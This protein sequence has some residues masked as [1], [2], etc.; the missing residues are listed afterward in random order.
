MCFQIFENQQATV[1]TLL[2]NVNDPDKK[3]YQLLVAQ[4]QSG[5]S[6][7]FICFAIE[8][9]IIGNVNTVY[10]ITGSRDINLRSQLRND[11]N[12]AIHHYIPI[13]KKELQ[14]KI[15][16]KQTEIEKIEIEKDV[17]ANNQNRNNDGSGNRYIELDQRV[18]VINREIGE[19][20]KDIDK[21]DSRINNMKSK[22]HI[23]FSQDIKNVTVNNKSLIIHD[24]SHYAQSKNNVPYKQF[25]N[26]NG[27]EHVLHGDF[28][29]LERRNIYVLNVSA[30]PFS[31]IVANNT[32][33]TR[34][35][36]CKTVVLCKPG[37]GYKGVQHFRDTNHIIYVNKKIFNMTYFKSTIEKEKNHVSNRYVIV[38]THCADKDSHKIQNIARECD[39]DYISIFGSNENGFDIL[40]RRPAK[41]T[42]V[43]ICGKARMG[44]RLPHG[45]IA[46]VFE[47]SKNPNADTVLQGLLGRVCGYYTPRIIEHE[48]EDSYDT[49]NEDEDDEYNH[50]PKIYI[51]DYTRED[52]NK[53][54]DAWD[55]LDESRI[56]EIKKATNITSKSFQNIEIDAEGNKWVKIVPFKFTTQ[57]CYWGERGLNRSYDEIV[58][59]I[60]NS[61]Q[62]N[63][64]THNNNEYDIEQV[65]RRLLTMITDN[66]DRIHHRR[67]S[68]GG[69]YDQN[70]LKEKLD[71]KIL[72]KLR[73]T[74]KFNNCIKQYKTSE[75][76]PFT[77]YHHDNNNIYFMGYIPYDDSHHK[78]IKKTLKVEVIN[79]CNYVHTDLIIDEDESIV[80]PNFNGGQIIAFPFNETHNNYERFKEELVIAIERTFGDNIIPGCSKCI[81]SMSD[82]DRNKIRSNACGIYLAT[83][84]FTDNNI[85]KLINEIKDSHNVT[86]KF[87]KATGRNPN[88]FKK[89]KNIIW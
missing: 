37:I 79:K 45:Y 83:S 14:K 40:K 36:E 35:L 31:E 82:I 47:L 4:M 28:S 70:N 57:Q 49:T 88:G 58:T 61:L 75:V 12:E 85:K 80:I 78:A 54:I 60:Y 22:F 32:T 5:K 48:Q 2:D 62:E 21:I 65:K 41:Q 26:K 16:E 59:A 52:I 38:R 6:G 74:D 8:M 18:R 42:V 34:D 81:S 29:E 51:S 1:Q 23:M 77:I 43:H 27:L 13:E 66:S 15:I 3:R 44:Q 68:E 20:K 46:I 55:N 64:I 87:N 11:F 56:A 84:I 71:Y 76:I 69:V 53:Y 33:R 72:N 89:F 30:T 67:F 10:I 73:Y 86:I 63:N 19:L 25:Y 17:I 7:I 24:E 9:M 39:Y 50:L